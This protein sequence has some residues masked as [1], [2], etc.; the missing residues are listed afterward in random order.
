MTDIEREA[1]LKSWTLPPSDSEDQRAENACRIVRAAVKN[2]PQLAKWDID[3]FIQGSY[4]NNTNVRLQSDVDVCVC[5]SNTITTDYLFA[6]GRSDSTEGIVPATYTYTQFKNDLQQAL[7]SAFGSGNVTRGNK[8]FNIKENSYRVTADV[9]PC[10]E[11][12]RYE[13]SASYEKGTSLWPDNGNAWIHNFPAQHYSNG[14]SKNMA[15]SGYFKDT[16]RIMKNMRNRMD[17]HGVASAKPIASFFNECLVWNTP[18]ACLM[19][20]SWGETIRATL[21]HLWDQLESDEKCGKWGQVSE[22]LYLFRRDYSRAQARDWV[23][24]A[25]NWLEF[26]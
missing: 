10:I 15:T 9:V 25:W 16:V 22:M 20:P 1:L 8:A 26:K 13:A 19:L 17:E 14:V 12:R 23:H 5:L 3:I 7:I 18:N 6:P 21:V 4:K 2:S 11:H 24:A